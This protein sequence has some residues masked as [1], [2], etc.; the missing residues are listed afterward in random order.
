MTIMKKYILKLL[1]FSLPIILIICPSLLVL[2]MAGEIDGE[3]DYV[4]PL[5]KNQLIGLAYT[6]IREAYK[7]KMTDSILQPEIIALGS[8]RIMQVKSDFISNDYHFYNAGGAVN[9]IYQYQLFLKE[10]SY[11]QKL[12]IISIDQFLFNPNY[13]NQI[14]SFNPKCYEFPKHNLPN[15]LNTF[16]HDLFIGK[17]VFNKIFHNKNRNIGLNAIINENGYKY[18]GTH[19][20]KNLINNQL[21]E[22]Y[23]FKDTFQRIAQG[24][25]RFEYREH[26]DTTLVGIIN[27]FLNECEKKGIAVVAIIPPFAPAVLRKMNDTGKYAYLHEIY[28]ILIPCF[29]NHKHCYLH[30]YTDITAMNVYNYDFIDGFHGSEI[31]YCMLI[32][33]ILS[34]TPYLKKYFKEDKQL[35]QFEKEYNKRK[36]RYHSI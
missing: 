23:N 25:R 32:R 11:T 35:R 30:D 33:D 7:F 15:I 9:N 20:E 14:A 4:M 3:S 24:N 5:Q 13:Q 28:D 8:S 34:Q 6:D 16:I 12:L 21:A 2:Y 27:L 18:D 26:A 31:I 22:D 1:L 17:I 36:I 29:K 19:Q 10:L